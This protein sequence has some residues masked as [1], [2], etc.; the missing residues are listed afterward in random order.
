ML[1]SSCATAQVFTGL[2]IAMNDNEKWLEAA[3]GLEQDILYLKAAL[4]S[5]TRRA[6]VGLNRSIERLQIAIAVYR[7]NA[8]AGMRWPSPDD[9]F[10]IQVLSAQVSTDMR[11]QFKFMQ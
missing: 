4:Q 6:A 3:A 10:C 9:L 1:R 5:A 2:E 11:R 8:A 7:K